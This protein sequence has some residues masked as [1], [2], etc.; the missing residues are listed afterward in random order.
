MAERQAK[1]RTKRT[2]QQRRSATTRRRLIE[3]ARQVFA[4]RGLDMAR[5][6]EITER[7]DLGKGTFYYH[8]GSKEKIVGEVIQEVVEELVAVIERR[9]R[10]IADLRELLS[11]LIGAHIEFFCNRWE[12][13][14]L[15]F[16]GRTDLTLETSY[17]GIETPFFKYLEYVEDLLASVIKGRLP[18]PVL[19]RIACAVA[20]FVSGYYAFAAIGSGD[21]D[22]DAPF[23]ALRGAM[24]ASLAR[25]IQEA[26]AAQEGAVTR[27]SE[28]GN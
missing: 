5:I 27:G 19:R 1:G 7:A 18:G 12:D 21:E 10:G 25:F 20:G 28:G 15:Y 14:V 17:A 4:E 9:C 8:F 24:A 2:R 26:V 11:T 6:D 3:A 23:R 22:V 13:F 16:Q